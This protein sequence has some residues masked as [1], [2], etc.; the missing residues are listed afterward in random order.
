L[1]P[2]LMVGKSAIPYPLAAA[3][4][5]MSESAVRVAV[6]RLRQRYRE[7][8]RQEISQTLSDP[9]QADEELRTL[10]TAFTE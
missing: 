9:T 2:I 3:A 7:L 8:L 10:F 1:K 4:L 6:H 5:D